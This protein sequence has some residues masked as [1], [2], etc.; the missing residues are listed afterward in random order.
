MAFDIL[1]PCL[2]TGIEAHTGPIRDVVSVS[3]GY[4]SQI[5]ARMRCD[6]GV[7]FVKGLQSKHK[8]AWTQRKEAEINPYLDGLSP[9]LLGHI[10]DC[11]WELLIFEAVEGHHP[12]FAPGSADLPVVAGLLSRLS[13]TP[14]PSLGLRPMEERLRGY[15]ANPSDADLFSGEALVHTDPNGTNVI[16]AGSSAKLVDWAWAS[17]GAAWVDAGYWA[18][19]LMAA[20]D[21]NPASAERWAS[22]VPAWRQAS[23]EALTAFAQAK[24]NYWDQVAGDAAGTFTAS[25]RDAAQQW[26]RYRRSL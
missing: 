13:R 9:A 3:A 16:V 10:S 17:R 1:P 8:R 7:Y 26:V 24:A 25:V 21:H 14:C 19:W 4:N 6:K 22:E 5:A 15:V 2:V 11:G 20:G 18:L 23:P 12:D